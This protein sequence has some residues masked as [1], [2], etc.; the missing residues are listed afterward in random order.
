MAAFEL[1]APGRMLFGA[2]VVAQAVPALR[3]LGAKRVLLVTGR[4]TRRS[5]SF[6][7]SLNVQAVMHTIASE[8]TLDMVNEGRA[9]AVR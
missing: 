1:A 5:E 8:P 4:S 7:A 2:G 9:L 3:G 6:R